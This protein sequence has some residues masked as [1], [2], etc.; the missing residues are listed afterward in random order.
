MFGIFKKK[1]EQR[2][3]K[4]IVVDCALNCLKEKCP[5]WV[6]LSRIIDQGTPNE[7]LIPEGRCATAWIPD[8]LIEI[9]DTL[10]GLK[11]G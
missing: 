3:D 4:Y 2:Q 10:A 9:K 5:K 6:V 1:Q 8:M 7:K 11:K